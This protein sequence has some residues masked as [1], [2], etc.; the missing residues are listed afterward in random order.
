MVYID[1][2]EFVFEVHTKASNSS[3]AKSIDTAI[4]Q[5]VSGRVESVAVGSN[6]IDHD[7]PIEDLTSSE[8]AC[9]ELVPIHIVIAVKVAYAWATNEGNK[10]TEQQKGVQKRR[11]KAT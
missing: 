4:D 9:E 7:G 1:A 3:S 2:R 8:P 6:Y 10:G 5:G 11:N